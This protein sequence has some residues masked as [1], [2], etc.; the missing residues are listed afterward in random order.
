[1]YKITVI[2]DGRYHNVMLGARYCFGKAKAKKLAEFFLEEEC[3][4]TVEKFIRS[5][6]CYCWS[7]IEAEIA[8]GWAEG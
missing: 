3:E 1:M 5:S 7:D 8:F 6:S 2:T 4:V